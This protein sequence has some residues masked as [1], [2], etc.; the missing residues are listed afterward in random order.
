VPERV[1]PSPLHDTV[2][3]LSDFLFF[4]LS[5]LLFLNG[6]SF[7]MTPVFS[8]FPSHFFFLQLSF[9]GAGDGLSG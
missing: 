3:F 7:N 6:A 1:S 8:F 2:A 5:H 9:F 4:L